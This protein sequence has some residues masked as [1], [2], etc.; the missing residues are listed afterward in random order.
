L[1]EVHQDGAMATSTIIQR[2]SNHIFT[3]AELA[4][5]PSN[6][7]EDSYVW[8]DDLGASTLHDYETIIAENMDSEECPLASRSSADSLL[9][10]ADPA[11]PRKIPYKRSLSQSTVPIP[12]PTGDYRSQGQPSH[13]HPYI[14]D[15]YSYPRI[16]TPSPLSSLTTGQLAEWESTLSPL[17]F[18]QARSPV[19]NP[20]S[21]FQQYNAQQ[22]I[23]KMNSQW[24]TDM[25]TAGN[26]QKRATE[27][28][29]PGS[30]QQRY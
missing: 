12:S 27:D 21:A 26:E 13:Y 1:D 30:S 28:S 2:V 24:A 17:Q 25:R 19:H 10:K 6:D 15:C 5:S 4:V 22:D 18:E 7:P 16:Q 8:Y 29:E 14:Q 23:F 3:E 9:E 11:A 20:G